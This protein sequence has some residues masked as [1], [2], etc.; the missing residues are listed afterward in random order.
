MITGYDHWEAW[1]AGTVN[2][3]TIKNNVFFPTGPEPTGNRAIFVNGTYKS[4][5]QVDISANTNIGADQNSWRTTRATLTLTQQATT[6]WVFD[7]NALLVFPDQIEKVV[8]S[9]TSAS[10]TW[11]H[12]V[13][14]PANRGV[15]VVETSVPVDATVSIEVSQGLTP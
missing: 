4:F 14:R 3:L 1:P 5:R 6:K 10:T 15:V 8:Y 9:V 7:F 2:A 11:F 13:A 12:H